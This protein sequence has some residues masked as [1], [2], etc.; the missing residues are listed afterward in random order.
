[1]GTALRRA[2]AAVIVTLILGS[3]AIVAQQSQG[4]WVTDKYA[5]VPEPSE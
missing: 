1:M 5:K 2:S 4:R 3:W